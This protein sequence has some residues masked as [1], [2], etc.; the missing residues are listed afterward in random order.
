MDFKTSVIG[1]SLVLITACGGGSGSGNSAAAYKNFTFVDPT[2]GDGNRF[3]VRTVELANGN[4]AIRSFDSSIATQNGAVHLY[5]PRTQK[6]IKSF[7]GDEAY[8]LIGDTLIP[9]ENS[10]LVI[11]S[12]QD[13]ANSNSD[14][15]VVMLINGETGEQIGSSMTGDQSNDRLGEVV[16]ALSNGNFVIASRNDSDSVNN[17]NKA[18]S[19]RLINGS[20]GAQIGSTI[21]GDNAFD[22]FG[23][24]VTAL[25]NGNFVVISVNAD[26]SDGMGGFISGVG[27]V[28]LVDGTTGALIGTPITG[29]HPGDTLGRSGVHA[30]ANGHY[31]I[32][33]SWDDVDD[34]MGGLLTDAGSVILVNGTTGAAITTMTGDNANDQF[35]SQG[36][37]SLTNDEFMVT[38]NYD[39]VAG[40]ADAGSV[41]FFNA[42]TG[43]QIGVTLHGSSANDYFGLG[44]RFQMSNGNIVITS[45]LYNL[46]ATQTGKVDLINGS[47]KANIVTLSEVEADA[48]FGLSGVRDLNNGNFVV[49]SDRKDNMGA[50]DVGS[51][52]IF[53]GTTGIQVGSTVYGDNAGDRLGSSGV[54]VLENGYF[55]IASESDDVN[56]L[57][58]A[59][60]SMLFDGATGNQVGSTLAG[61]NAHD[62]LGMNGIT[63]LQGSDNYVIASSKVDHDSVTTDVGSVILVDGDTGAQIG[64]AT[65]GDDAGDLLGA[66]A[67]FG[68]KSILALANGD[69]LVIN[70]NND[71]EGNANVGK[72]LYRLGR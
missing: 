53:N 21:Y 46:G 9:L 50:A 1:L 5:N 43:A 38:S 62:N 54:H 6:L 37:M 51:I 10:N 14:A 34:G 29:D 8:D 28:A 11:A 30:L 31:T 42:N 23:D 40:N 69:Y 25:P 13:N 7:Y 4:I 68:D 19:I 47:T 72:V 12:N 35:G 45:R 67:G 36:V 61:A 55:V 22:N 64:D 26:I 41:K 57:T 33:S 59:G 44:N 16:V 60:S 18:G 39:D 3:G 15:G 2:A 58:N 70:A 17:V 56:G 24:R 48:Q 52:K 63:L 20:T 32:S 65:F 66:A 49:V 71:D 27:S